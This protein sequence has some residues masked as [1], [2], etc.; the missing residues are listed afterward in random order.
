MQTN[1]KHHC[2]S[3]KRLQLI[4]QLRAQAI[5]MPRNHV[6]Q[7]FLLGGK[8]AKAKCWLVIGK[9]STCLPKLLDGRLNSHPLYIICIYIHMIF[10]T[11]T[12]IYND[13]YIYTIYTHTLIDWCIYL[14]I[15]WFI[16]RFFDWSIHWFIHW[17]IVSCIR[18][19][20]LGPAIPT[21]CSYV[22]SQ[23]LVCSIWS[24][25]NAD[26]PSAPPQRNPAVLPALW[27][28]L[29]FLKKTDNDMQ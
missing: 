20:E 9:L 27:F 1:R 11:H 23:N 3:C 14:L 19:R 15:D 4:F 8:V 29:C 28:G 7:C 13:I 10:D 18:K 17:L 12:Q 5:A 16:G 21:C 22:G 24:P 25:W 6:P 2:K 26:N